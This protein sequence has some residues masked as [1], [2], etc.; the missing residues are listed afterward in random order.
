VNRTGRRR[1]EESQKKD[2]AADA[3]AAAIKQ[4]REGVE[5]TIQESN[6]DDLLSALKARDTRGTHVAQY[7]LRTVSPAL[8]LGFAFPP[9]QSSRWA[10]SVHGRAVCQAEKTGCTFHNVSAVCKGAADR[11]VLLSL[12]AAITHASITRAAVMCA[13]IG[14]RSPHSAIGIALGWPFDCHLKTTRNSVQ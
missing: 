12:G 3:E 14:C 2:A 5:R 9:Q 7:L 13:S 1:A 10:A 6:F 11:S 8:C 4:A